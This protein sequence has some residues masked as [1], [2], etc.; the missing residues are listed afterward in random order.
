MAASYSATLSRAASV[1]VSDADAGRSANANLSALDA[2]LAHGTGAD[3]LNLAYR[4][5]HTVADS[6]TPQLLDLRD[7]TLR[8][9]WGTA[10]VLAEVVHLRLVA[11]D[12]NTVDVAVGGGTDAWDFGCGTTPFALRPGQELDVFVSSDPAIPVG[13]GNDVLQL[14]IASGTDQVVQ[15]MILGRDA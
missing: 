14:A 12:E 9:A 3:Q 13:A 8:D 5:T 11:S 10:L 7:G 4:A 15:V 1:A 6:S 2:A